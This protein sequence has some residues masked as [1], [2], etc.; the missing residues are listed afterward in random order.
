MSWVLQVELQ[1]RWAPADV[2]ARRVDA[3]TAA[4]T[5]FGFLLTFIHICKGK[6]T[7]MDACN[8][9]QPSG[10]TLSPSVSGSFLIHMEASRG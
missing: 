9:G 1:A 8:C 7:T 10:P 2:A 5:D 3:D 6:E 4:F